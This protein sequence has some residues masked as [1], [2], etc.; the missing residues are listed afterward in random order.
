MATVTNFPASAIT[1]RSATVGGNVTSTGGAVPEV[2]LYYGTA[3]GGTNAGAWAQSMYMGNQVGNFSQSITGLSVNTSYY[4]RVLAINPAGPAWPPSSQTFNTVSAVLATVTNLPAFNVEPGAAILSG[5]VVATGGDA[6]V[7]TIYYG[8]S[9]GGT[10]P[11]AWAQSVTLLGAQDG[12]FDNWH[13]VRL[14]AV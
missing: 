5:N 4:F 10:T 7:V 3:D 11:G 9:N 12:A 14:L 6:P 1:T 8:P 13:V 2:F